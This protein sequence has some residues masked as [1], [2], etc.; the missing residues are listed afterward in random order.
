MFED[1]SYNRPGLVCLR[2]RNSKAEL[3]RAAPNSP[4]IIAVTDPGGGVC[5]PGNPAIKQTQA[6]IFDSNVLNHGGAPQIAGRVFP[7]YLFNRWFRVGAFTLGGVRDLLVTDWMRFGLGA[8]LTFYHQPS[9]LDPIYG[10]ETKSWR[11]FL[12]FRPGEMK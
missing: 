5:Q 6:F 1:N 4:A 7:G 9:A 8:D 2:I 12:R 11:V 10:R 3:P